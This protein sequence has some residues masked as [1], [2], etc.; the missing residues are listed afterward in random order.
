MRRYQTNGFIPFSSPPPRIHRQA[1]TDTFV[2]GDAIFDDGSGY[3]TNA[4]TAFANTFL[5]ICAADVDNSAGSQGSV[6]VEIYPFD[7]DTLYIVPVAAAALITRTAVGTLVD[8]ENNDDI[9][10][11]DAVTTG[12]GFWIEEI[13]V[14]TEAVAAN[15]YGYA[16]GRFRVQATQA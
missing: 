11:S 15:T 1:D 16:I 8:L 5:G 12:I 3:A 9:D 6:D 2:K 4:I 7:S 10:I 14:S 13:D